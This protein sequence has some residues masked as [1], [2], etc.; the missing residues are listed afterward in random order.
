LETF[1][2]K[3]FFNFR[4]EADSNDSSGKTISHTTPNFFLVSVAARLVAMVNVSFK[5]LQQS[6][7]A[8]LL[9]ST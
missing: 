2:P 6:L 5:R 9:F 3:K 4:L 7:A 8:S 1:L